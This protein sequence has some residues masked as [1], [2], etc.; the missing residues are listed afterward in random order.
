[1]FFIQVFHFPNPHSLH[2]RSQRAISSASSLSLF[3]GATMAIMMQHGGEYGLQRL[4]SNLGSIVMT[5][6]SGIL[7]D[8]FSDRAGFQDFR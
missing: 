5:P 8:H 2:P 7:I 4:Y 6:I 3:D 1:M